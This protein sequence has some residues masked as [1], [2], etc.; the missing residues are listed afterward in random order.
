MKTRRSLPTLEMWVAASPNAN[1]FTMIHALAWS[2]RRYGGATGARCD[3][4]VVFGREADERDIDAGMPWAKRL[5]VRWRYTRPGVFER[6]GVYGTALD[7]FHGPFTADVVA[8]L[9]AD[10]VVAG[11]LDG[12]ARDALRSEAF[13]GLPAH[14]P[15]WDGQDRWD[16]LFSGVGLGPAPRTCTPSGAAIYPQARGHSMPPY[17][18]LGVLVAPRPMMQ[19][20]GSEMMDELAAVNT[21]VDSYYRCQLAVSARLCRLGVPWRSLPLRDNFPNDPDFVRHAP[22]Q[23]W[24]W[25]IVHALR[26]GPDL[27]KQR[28]FANPQA[29]RAWLMRQDVRGVNARIQRLLHPLL[30]ELPA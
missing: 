9:D 19:V 14:I 6:F 8:M 27:D 17:F 25:R 29:L 13:A 12:L 28:D 7:R 4:R 5:G 22:W 24:H 23:A 11:S 2:L 26:R 30:A 1:F 10:T 3:L 21:V 18:N 15:P 16:E 20:V